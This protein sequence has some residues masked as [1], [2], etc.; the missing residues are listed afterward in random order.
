MFVNWIYVFLFHFG[1]FFLLRRQKT[2]SAQG[3]LQT[4]SNQKVEE[5]KPALE[6]NF[7]LKY[8]WAGHNFDIE[9]LIEPYAGCPNF[10]LL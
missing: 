4:R 1:H 2:K 3:Q 5:N 9:Y 7:T 10:H 8:K 6:L